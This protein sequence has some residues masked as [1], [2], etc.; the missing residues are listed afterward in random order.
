MVKPKLAIDPID[1]RICPGE[2]AT[3]MG[4][5]AH[6]FSWTAS[7]ADASL[8]GQENS[9]VIRVSPKVTTTYTMVG[10]GS[11]NCDATPLTKKVTIV[12]LPVSSVSLTPTFIDTDNPKMVLRDQSTCSVASSWLFPDGQVKTGKEVSH[13]FNDC[14]GYDSVYVTLTSYNDL[15]CPKEYPF[16]IPVNVFTVWFPT[17]FTP[18]SNDG[19]EKFTIYTINDYQFFHIYIYNRRGELVFESDD[20]NFQ[21]DGTH[22]GEPCQQGAYVYTCRFRKPGTTTLSTVQGT[23]TLIR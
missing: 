8:S 4:S 17:A 10:H 23:V 15:N 16:A 21:W 1:G 9:D 7:P 18:G 12:P 5:D 19:N 2:V 6:H 3:L 13:T 22:N 14:I 11:N 20:V